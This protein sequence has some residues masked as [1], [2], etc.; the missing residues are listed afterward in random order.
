M[1]NNNDNRQD[2][3][4]MIPFFSI[5]SKNFDQDLVILKKVL[6]QFEQRTHSENAYK[7]SE[8]AT[9]AAGWWF[10]DIFFKHDFV[11]KIFQLLL[12]P[13]YSHKDKKA[14][15]LKIV[16]TFQD[17]IKKNGSD[18]RIKMFGDIPIAAGWWSWLLR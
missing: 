1:D 10:Y 3:E 14:A 7:F 13:N 18:A 4:E 2:Y 8:R 16:D 12:P 9:L 5:A 17:Q 6:H 15:T 11:Q